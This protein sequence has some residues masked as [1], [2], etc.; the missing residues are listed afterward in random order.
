MTKARLLAGAAVAAL[1][2]LA[3]APPARAVYCINCATEVTTAAVWLQQA[4]DM[5]QQYGMLAQQYQAIAHQVEAAIS[6]ARALGSSAL[7]N[8]LPTVDQMAGVYDGLN[9]GP[10]ADIADRILTQQRVFAPAGDDWRAQE[11]NRQAQSL[12][13]MQALATQ[14]LTSI[15]QRQVELADFMAQ[16]GESPDIQQTAAL[17]ARL[18]LEQNFVAGQQLQAINLQVMASQMD[19]LDRARLEQKSRQDAEE[20]YNHYDTGGE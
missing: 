9:L 15:Q 16:I 12:A 18:T 2:L 14:S 7:R 4:A 10:V 1:C 5:V 20:L 17:Q 11:I 6:T 3:Q 13:G 8:P 19:R